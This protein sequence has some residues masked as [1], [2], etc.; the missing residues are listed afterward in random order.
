MQNSESSAAEPPQSGHAIPPGSYVADPTRSGL[1]FQAKA[2]GLVWVH[3]YLPAVGGIVNLAEGRLAGT[4]AVAA[5]RVSTGLRARDWHLRTS[6]YLHTARHPD[7]AMSV[8]G[9]DMASGHAEFQVVVRGK[10]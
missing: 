4:G 2:F 10:S 8:Q 5:H 7:I 3:G 9:A 6:H 1:S